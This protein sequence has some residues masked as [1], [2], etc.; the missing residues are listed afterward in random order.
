M[1]RTFI[2]AKSEFLTLVR[3][4][5]FIIGLVLMPVMMGAFF[6]FMDYAER[7]TDTTS[8]SVAVIDNTGVLFAPLSAAAAEHNAEFVAPDGTRTGP[9]FILTL[10]EATG[11]PQEAI[12]LALSDRVRAKELFAFLDI[13]GDVIR[14]SDEDNAVLYYTETTSY[15]ALPTWLRTTLDDEVRRVR[16]AGAGIDQALVAQLSAR[17]GLSR[18]GLL[19][20]T[21]DGGTSEAREVGTLERMALPVFFL[22][23]MFMAVMTA[24]Q[25]L[26]NAVIEEKMSKISEVLLG[27]VTPFQLLM[28]KLLGVVLI[29]MVLSGVY[30]LGGIYALMSIGRLDLFDPVLISWFVVFLV[31]ATLLYG[32]IF[33]ALG[34]ACS[35]LHDAQSMMQPAMV[36][37]LLAYLGSFIVIQNPNS[38]LSVG[39][40]FFPTMAPFAMVLRMAMPPGPPLWQVL[41]SVSLL[42]AG[43]W[44]CVWAGGRIFRI[45]ILMQGKAPTLPE[46]VKWIGK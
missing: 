18:F 44:F 30:F 42:V 26:M 4:K 31:C 27:S 2:I 5:A 36:L 43:T 35:D 20:R 7:E 34:S 12:K 25:H 29:V 33:L 21:A 15:G 41:L 19:T 46:L 28:G 45:G 3:T 8:R 10:V 11:E 9:E 6:F 1:T 23:L 39:S 17:T 40:S 37:L 16:F 38:G 24:A 14:R 32:S 13:P 22:V